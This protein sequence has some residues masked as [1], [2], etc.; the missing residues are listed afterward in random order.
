METRQEREDWLDAIHRDDLRDLA[1]ERAAIIEFDG[2]VPRKEAE[3][4]A[5]AEFTSQPE[6]F[7]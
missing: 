4:L 7:K 3:R 6:L 1:R 5:V 2:K